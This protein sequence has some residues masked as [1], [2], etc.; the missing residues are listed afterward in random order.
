MNNR[1]ILLFAMFFLLVITGYQQFVALPRARAAEQA[2]KAQ[3]QL[4]DQQ[5]AAAPAAVVGPD[6]AYLTKVPASQKPEE[7]ITLSLPHAEV[8]FSSKGAGIKTYL[9]KDILGPVDLT[10]YPGVGYLATLPEVDFAEYSRT[11]DSITFVGDVIPGVRVQKTYRL[12]PNGLAQLTV[13]FSN[14]TQGS[15]E[16]A[17]WKFNFG[18]GLA[19]VKSEMKDNQTESKAVY[20]VQEPGKKNPTLETFT[21]NEKQPSLPW[22]WA[23]LENRYF[24]AVLIPQN[25]RPGALTTQR[26]VIGQKKSFWSSLGL[27]S[28]ELKGPGLQI[29]VPGITLEAGASEVYTSH[30]YVGPKD[31]QLFQ[32]A[33]FAPYHLERSIAFGFFGALGK[34]ARNVLELFY[35]WTGNYGVAIIMLT[36]LLQLIL[37][38]F[39]IMQLKSA[40]QMKKIQPQV[41]R[42][43]EKYKSDPAA[44]QR[45]T[46]A[47][48]Q[49]YHVNPLS[50]CLPLLIQMPIFFALFNALRTSWALHGAKFVWWLTDLSAK[51]PYYVLPILMGAVMFF[52][53]RGNVP[54][55]TDPAQ[56]AVFKYMPLIFTLLFMNFPSGLVL[57]WLTN[58]LL[59]YGIQTLVNKKMIQAK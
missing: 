9:Y 33:E 57:Y 26:P 11:R 17:D 6:G 13:Q 7:F 59:T 58:S 51:D 18:P 24:L 34:I 23:G 32:S 44:L 21:N 3:L 22:Q 56:A 45:E 4:K 38:R 27:A 29:T 50:G 55:G 28:D 36:V 31:Y 2:A 19:T 47:L 15:V 49:K 54:P 40:A 35:K 42:I 14:R 8:T 16:L 5:H 46:L 10:P 12:E 1:P 53:Q 43:Q 20:L 39:T 48:Y 37:C 52:Q 30:F 41:K 25:F